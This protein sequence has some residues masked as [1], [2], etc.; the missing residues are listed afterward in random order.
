MD[1]R[2]IEYWL[3]DHGFSKNEK[4]LLTTQYGEAEVIVSVTDRS[5][6]VHLENA[7]RIVQIG[8]FHPGRVEL[9]EFGMVQGMGLTTP[10]LNAKN[11]AWPPSWW[12]DEY[13]AKHIE[14]LDRINPGVRP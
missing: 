12:P 6:R 4:G 2:D 14:V 1:A 10:F 3:V 8:S 9:D 11:T 13:A 5:I 7:H